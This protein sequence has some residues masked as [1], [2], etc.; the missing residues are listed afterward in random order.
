MQIGIPIILTVTSLI[1]FSSLSYTQGLILGHPLEFW[2]S[3]DVILDGVVISTSLNETDNLVR[4]DVNVKQYFKNPKPENVITVYGPGTYN[5]K[6]FYPKFFEK[7][8]RALFYLKLVDGKYI[9]L[10]HSII[11]TQECSP[12]DMIGLS[13]LPGEPIGRGGPTLFFDPY[14]TCNGY[15]Y[16]VDYLSSTL[17]PLKQVESGIKLEDIKCQDERIM[18]VKIDG[19]PACVKPET[20]SKLVGRGWGTAENWIKIENTNYAIRYEIDG[21]KILSISAYSAY[22]NPSLPGETQSTMLIIMLDARENGQLSIVMP[23]DVID[24]KIQANDDGFFVLLNQTEVQYNETKTALD[25]TLEFSFPS[26]IDRMEI[27][28]HGYYNDKL[29]VPP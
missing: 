9:I 11:A 24:S 18:A 2:D 25:R 14:Q 4:H 10:P 19:T 6:W 7:G 15:L 20:K 16:S 28:G 8:D 29:P 23:R 3:A 27:I 5:E 26:G 1:L 22:T 17:K 13:T 21:G 12:R